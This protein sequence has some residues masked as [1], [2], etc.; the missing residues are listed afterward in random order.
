MGPRS[1]LRPA[2]GTQGQRSKVS[3]ARTAIQPCGCFRWV[4][5]GRVGVQAPGCVH[6]GR[7]K[8]AG[9]RGAQRAGLLPLS[10]R[11]RCL[12]PCRP[13]PPLLAAE[14]LDLEPGAPRR[15][16]S[17]GHSMAHKRSSRHRTQRW[18]PFSS[19]GQRFGYF[20]CGQL[21]LRTNTNLLRIQ[22]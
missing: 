14:I 16:L 21:R 18:S 5:C 17:A 15:G 12:C 13:A 8:G 7:P 6:R 2:K 3:C 9:G 10:P 1:E 20:Q 4:L 11:L 22:R 19:S